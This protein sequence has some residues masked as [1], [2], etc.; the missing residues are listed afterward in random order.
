MK[1]FIV[2]N[3]KIHETGLSICRTEGIFVV[4]M[5]FSFFRITGHL[6]DRLKCFAGQNEKMPVLSDSPALFAK[7]GT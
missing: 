5:L 4:R 2:S 3:A 1:L 7:T 6:S